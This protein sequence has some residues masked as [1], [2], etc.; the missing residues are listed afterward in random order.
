MNIIILAGAKT[1]EVG[2]YPLYLTEINH[3][4]LIQILCENFPANDTT[5]II[6][7]INLD[8]DKKYNISKSLSQISNKP[9]VVLCNKTKGALITALLCIDKINLDDS[10]LVINGNEYIDRDIN[11]MVEEFVSS[12]SDVSIVCFE[13]IHPRYSHA[14]IENNTVERVVF[15]NVQGS[16]ACTGMVWFRNASMFFDSACKAILKK[17]GSETSF[18]FNEV[19]NQMILDDKN[20]AAFEIESKDYYP[21]KSSSDHINLQ[22]I[23]K[24]L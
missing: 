21:L 8:D 22:E 14:V 7:P 18:Y 5:N 2:T 12:D 15:H 1:T 23:I 6:I 11:S 13:S 16:K 19:I 24:E 17:S 9:Q 4:P 3:I 10:L 20:V